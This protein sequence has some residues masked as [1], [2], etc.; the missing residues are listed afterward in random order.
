MSL[1]S[2]STPEPVDS[3]DSKSAAGN[4]AGPEAIAGEEAIARAE[5]HCLQLQFHMLEPSNNAFQLRIQAVNDPLTDPRVLDHI[6]VNGPHFLLKR[7]ADH[8]STSPQ[9]LAKLACHEHHEVRAAL[10]E[11][12]NLSLELQWL[13]S[14]D[15]HP[16]VRY[17]AA[18]SYT[19]SPVVLAALLEDSNPYVADRAR[20]TL[21]RLQSAAVLPTRMPFKVAEKPGNNR[22]RGAG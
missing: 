13:L 3:I 10:A 16:D 19:L 1:D 5:A 14:Q 2:D 15:E 20:T 8:P 21:Q 7:V 6:A 9:T 22:L 17:A 11:N 18:E 12:E 4:A